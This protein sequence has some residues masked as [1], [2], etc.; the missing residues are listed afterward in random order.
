[1]S[2]LPATFPQPLDVREGSGIAS[3]FRVEARKL[4]AQLSTRLLVLVCLLGPFAFA[5]VLRVQSGTPADSLFGVWVH[6]SGFAIPF[7]VLGF[8]GSWG[9]PLIAGVLCGDM[10]SAEDRHG[11]WKTILTRSLTRR[12][13][14]AGKLAAAGL[15][16]LALLALAAISSLLAGVILVGTQPLVD[17]GGVLMSPARCLALVLASWVTCVL[18]MLAYTSLALLFSALSRN[19]IVGVLGPILVALATQL[20]DLIGRGVIVHMLL[21]GSAFDAWH[22]LLTPHVFLGPLLVSSVVSLVWIAAAVILAARRVVGDDALG[23]AEGTERRGWLGPLRGV[24]VAG[25]TLAVLA[26][27]SN[28]GPVGVTA[29]RLHVTVG[30]EFNR[31]ALLQERILGRQVPAGAQ[32]A[33]R[34]FCNKRA[35][36]PRGPGDWSCTINVYLPQPGRVPYQQA[37]VDYDVSVQSNGCYKAE[38]PPTFIGQQT[39]AN[40][41]GRQVVNPLFVVYGCFNIL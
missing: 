12:E 26:L 33:L 2:A 28:V 11:T 17:L 6:A 16:S 25:V 39:M 1:M 35:A 29:S 5:L 7:V 34:P 10:F 9:L 3:A 20:L 41:D 37:D 13:L 30:A 4:A 40:A 32:L 27:V 8:A 38:T 22:G 24:A 21:I 23:P 18:P 14:F 36:A 31:L 15:F 19:G